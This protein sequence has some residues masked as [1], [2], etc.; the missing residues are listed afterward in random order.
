MN[1]LNIYGLINIKTMA[2]YHDV[3]LQVDVVLLAD[4]MDKFRQTCMGHY[5][6]DP[7]HF[8][9]LPNFSWTVMLKMTNVNIE[10][11]RY[12]DMHDMIRNNIRGGLCTIG[13]VRYVKANNPHMKE[14]YNP[15]EETSFILATDANNLY[16]KAMTGPLP[17]GNFE[18]VNPVH[19]ANDFVKYYDNDGEDCYILEV[20]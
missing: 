14:L 8:Y 1:L 2:E 4:V 7:S 5:K 10:L 15:D 13:S 11:M 20:I 12:I 18:W 19:I 16:G 17:Y 3:Y 9:T 6:L